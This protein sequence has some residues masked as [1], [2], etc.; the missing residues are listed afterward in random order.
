MNAKECARVAGPTA[1]RRDALGLLSRPNHLLVLE[2]AGQNYPSWWTTSVGELQPEQGQ[3]R[4]LATRET[5]RQCLHRGIQQPRQAGVPQHLVVLIHGR[6]STADQRMQ[7][8][9]QRKPAAFGARKLDAER[10]CGPT[11]T[12]PKGRMK[13]GPEMG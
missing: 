2:S 4:L 7:D 13:H 10:L 5:K 6:C 11:S 1:L 8:R 9:L 3:A 12:K